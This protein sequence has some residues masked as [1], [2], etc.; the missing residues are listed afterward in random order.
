MN[1]CVLLRISPTLLKSPQ[2]LHHFILYVLCE[3]N[4][5]QRHDEMFVSSQEL[6]NQS[7]HGDT[8]TEVARQT[9]SGLRS[10]KRQPG[11]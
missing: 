3:D 11:H 1:C 6:L 7:L 2:S 9:P 10:Y 4:D 8:T 5:G